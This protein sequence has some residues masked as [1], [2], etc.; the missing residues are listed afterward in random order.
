MKFRK[1]FLVLLIGLLSINIERVTA[2]APEIKHEGFSEKIEVPASLIDNAGLA[3]FD[4]DKCHEKIGEYKLYLKKLPNNNYSIYVDSKDSDTRTTFMMLMQNIYQYFYN[5]VLYG[6]GCVHMSVMS[7]KKIR[8]LADPSAVYSGLLDFYR[9]YYAYEEL[10]LYLS[11]ND[12]EDKKHHYTAGIYDYRT[13]KLLWSKDLYKEN[14]V[15]DYNRSSASLDKFYTEFE[16]K[17]R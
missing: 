13:G 5:N 4:Y 9:Y 17:C 16:S 6:N 7:D 15:G 8:I 10:S 2:E 1:L 14:L 11:D 3:E 12:P